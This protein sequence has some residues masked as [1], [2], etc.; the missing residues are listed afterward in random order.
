MSLRVALIMFIVLSVIGF[1]VGR[2]TYSDPV[3][4]RNNRALAFIHSPLLEPTAECISS[5][6][7]S[8]EG[9]DAILCQKDSVLVRCTA[10]GGAHD[11][12]CHLVYQ[13]GD[14]I[15]PEPHLNDGHPPQPAPKLSDRKL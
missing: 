13:P 2:E 11:P 6:E 5:G 12:E 7:G 8:D 3:R 4:H 14:V 10:G 15:G 9:V 1:V